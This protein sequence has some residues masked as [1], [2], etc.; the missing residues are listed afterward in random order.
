MNPHDEIT[1]FLQPIL[2]WLFLV[3]LMCCCARCSKAQ[4]NRD[5]SDTNQFTGI[6]STPNMRNLPFSAPQEYFSRSPVNSTMFSSHDNRDET[7]IQESHFA[8]SPPPAYN[9]VCPEPT[10]PDIALCSSDPDS[11]N[12]CTTGTADSQD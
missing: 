4:A 9:D 12:A 5:A 10:A 1:F 11:C 2:V 6:E 3:A 7:T 8:E